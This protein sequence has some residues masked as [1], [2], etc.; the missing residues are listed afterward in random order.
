MARIQY[1]VGASL[2][3]FIATPDDGL[4][5]LLQFDGFDGGQESYDAFIAGVGCIAMGRGTY[6]WLRK[7]GPG[8]WPYPGIPC[9]VFTRHEHAAPL[10]ADVTFVR[11][12]VREFVD[13]LKQDAQGR[14]VWVMGG[15]DLAA[16]FADAGLLDDLIVSLVPVVLG[17]G[18][19]LLPMA[20]PTP[21]LE[22]VASRTLGRGVVELRYL[23][24]EGGQG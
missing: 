5:W 12:D 15:G 21:P 16:Q 3:G 14:N 2:D 1:F 6:A 20:G 11:G 17:E 10:R 13:D 8:A 22:L 18:K 23:L 9:Y 7:H 19:R 4:E 24:R